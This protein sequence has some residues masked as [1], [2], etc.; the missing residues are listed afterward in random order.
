MHVNAAFRHVVAVNLVRTVE[1]MGVEVDPV[2]WVESFIKRRKVIMSMDG[3]EEVS[4]DVDMAVPQQPPIAPVIVVVNLYRLFGEDEKKEDKCEHKSIS[5]VNGV[6][7]VITKRSGGMHTM[8]GEK[9]G[10]SMS[11]SDR[12]CSS[13]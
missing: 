3:N 2:R 7:W 5:F 13:T 9:H 4:I 12:K 8:T 1:E 11:L 6:A 10:R